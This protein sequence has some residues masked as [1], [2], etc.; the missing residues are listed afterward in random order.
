MT[1]V[2]KGEVSLEVKA[3]EILSGEERVRGRTGGMRNGAGG[4]LDHSLPHSFTNAR[5]ASA[6][7][8]MLSSATAV[9]NKGV[10]S[11]TLWCSYC[12]RGI[13]ETATQINK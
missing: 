2:V 8:S 12:R 6:P 10:Q 1:A 9:V 11:L 5:H 3:E 13:R 4:R 7:G